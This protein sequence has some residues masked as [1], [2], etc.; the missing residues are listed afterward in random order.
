[1]VLYLIQ[2]TKTEQSRANRENNMTIQ[3]GS[4][5]ISETEAERINQEITNNLYYKEEKELI[6]KGK[7]KI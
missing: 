2:R 6:Y 1:M 7:E 5:Q 3:Y 4:K